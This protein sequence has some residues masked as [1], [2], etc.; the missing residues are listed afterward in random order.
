MSDD[1]R[2]EPE[3]AEPDPVE[4]SEEESTVLMMLDGATSLGEL[5][6]TTGVEEPRLRTVIRR[7]ESL[8]LLEGA[9][10]HLT[11]HPPAAAAPDTERVVEDDTTDV[12]RAAAEADTTEPPDADTTEVGDAAEVTDA[13]D[14]VTEPNGDADVTDATDVA[15]VAEEPSAE[16][17]PEPEEP[18]R[19]A[20]ELDYRKRFETE[21]RPLA[22]DAR[23]HLAATSADKPTLLALCFDPDVAVLRALLENPNV[24][25][26]HARLAA[27]HHRTQGGLDAL[28]ARGDFFR[29]AQVVRRLLRNPMLGEP[30]LRRLL[31]PKRLIEVYK[32]TNDRDVPERSRGS[33]RQVFRAKFT[34][35][36]PE[37]RCELIWSTEGRVLVALSG[38]TFDS[39]TSAMI[40]G[41]PVLSV[42]LIQSLAR[43]PATPPMILSHL[44]KQP[45]VKRQA[46]LRNMLLQHPNAPSDAKRRG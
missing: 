18:G 13:T 30:L 32:L 15:P 38:C 12:T 45:L 1:P 36:E 43:F 33:A 2:R 28:A 6:A 25:L 16:A 3:P 27:F 10:T 40:C 21:L 4:L 34:T 23:A 17:A 8:G 11:A 29:D 20:L 31:K 46:H 39:R 41:R 5:S 35:A 26:D 42:Q 7:L 24:G 14:V 44:L 9:P 37:E 22:A 19:A